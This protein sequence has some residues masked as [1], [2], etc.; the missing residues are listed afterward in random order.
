MMGAR[1][2]P[3]LFGSRK[4]DDSKTHYHSM[5]GEAACGRWE[6]GKLDKYL[7]GTHFWWIC[8][9]DGMQTL[10]GYD[11]PIKQL[12]RWGQ[13]MLGYN[14]TLHHRSH[15]LMRYVDAIKR[16]YETGLI[17]TYTMKQAALHSDSL[18]CHPN[19]Y[20]IPNMRY[21]NRRL[22]ADPPPISDINASD[23]VAA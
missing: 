1:I 7:C 21:V 19:S 9:Y 16:R 5:V 10:F 11:G 17:K 4:C 12:R 2:R 18:R 22:S 15:Q 23:P 8:D 3:V 14:C 13:E 6:F 20:A